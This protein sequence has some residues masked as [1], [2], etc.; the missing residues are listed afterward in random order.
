M[1]IIKI[2]GML[3][4]TRYKLKNYYLYYV[5]SRMLIL[6]LIFEILLSA[7]RTIEK[8]KV[9]EVYVKDKNLD[10]SFIHYPY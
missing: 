9:S 3:N 2:E 10:P 5:P 7:Q 8:K 4:I 1:K 6:M